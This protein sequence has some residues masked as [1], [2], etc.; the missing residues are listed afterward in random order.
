MPFEMADLSMKRT[1][2]IHNSI[3]PILHGVN[4]QANGNYASVSPRGATAPPTADKANERM[5]EGCHLPRPSGNLTSCQKQE[6]LQIIQRP[7]HSRQLQKNS[8]QN[9]SVKSKSYDSKTSEACQKGLFSLQSNEVFKREVQIINREHSDCQ[10][11]QR[12]EGS[13]LISREAEPLINQINEQSHDRDQTTSPRLT[14]KGKKQG[15][16][17]TT[18]NRKQTSSSM[19]KMYS[20][21]N[22]LDGGEKQA[23]LGK[24]KTRSKK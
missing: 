8:S 22:S 4:R 19:V 11:Q 2:E 18:S 6:T 23:C 10:S 24:R 13:L 7:R 21:K 14:R 15:R 20:P 1:Q 3:L 16:K 9:A 12:K 5:K 17:A